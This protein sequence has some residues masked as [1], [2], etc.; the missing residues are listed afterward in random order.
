MKP[1]LYLILVGIAF[2]ILLNC[3]DNKVSGASVNTGNTIAGV[4]VDNSGKVSAGAMVQ[5]L[6]PN[7]NPVT[8][9]LIEAWSTTTDKKGR[10]EISYLDSSTYNLEATSED[11]TVL[12]FKREVE[13]FTE[14]VEVTDLKLQ[15]PGKVIVNMPDYLDKETGHVYIPGTSLLFRMDSDPV[16][17]L[18]S[19]PPQESMQVVFSNDQAGVLTTLAEDVDVAPA[20]RVEV[21]QFNLW[22][23]QT[24]ITINTSTAGITLNKDVMGFPLLIRL[25]SENFSFDKAEEDGSDI[26]FTKADGTPLPYEIERWNS[27]LSLAEI[28]VR[29]DTIFAD[30]S[31]QTIVMYSGN[32]EAQSLSNGE[33]VFDS[34]GGFRSVWHLGENSTSSTVEDAVGSFD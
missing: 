11:E 14:A 15:A 7:H 4:L 12:L 22:A 30:K 10:F 24:Q 19:V 13:V 8:D 31:S 23:H 1:G 25:N 21:S 29:V 6:K 16:V 2:A 20:G 28:W 18:L 3:S 34:T 27:A 5:L 33:N 9:D 32:S 17:K 26:R